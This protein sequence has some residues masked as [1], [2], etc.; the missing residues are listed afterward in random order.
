MND[1]P[2]ILYDSP[3]AAS[4]KTVTGWVSR[5]GRFFG[6]QE[7]AAR[8]DGCTHRKCKTDGCE[9][10]IDKHS[11][12][13]CDACM[14]EKD[15][16][17]FEA[18]P[19]AAWDGKAMLF[20]DAHDEYFSDLEEAED[21]ASREGVALADLRLVICEPHF[22]RELDTEN[23]VDDLP[24]DGELP[25]DVQTALDAL[26]AAIRSAGPSCWFPGKC[27][28]DLSTIAQPPG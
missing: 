9:T 27:A 5:H 18:R 24:E 6:Q 14:K 2:V 25:D 1:K 19:K 7:D 8:W 12:I 23:W 16:A 20:S 28:L 21:F 22:L 4:I 13:F 10:L 3:E 26:N 15:L 11:F 17:K